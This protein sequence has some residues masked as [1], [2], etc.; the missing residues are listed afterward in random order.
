MCAIFAPE[1][2]FIIQFVFV[3]ETAGPG[4]II[5]NVA[6][7]NVVHSNINHHPMCADCKNDVRSEG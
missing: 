4:T 5:N 2:D 7:T 6:V 1:W 3:P